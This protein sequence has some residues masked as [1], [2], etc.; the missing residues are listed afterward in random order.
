MGSS[1]TPD[2]RTDIV[3][4]MMAMSVTLRTLVES[5]N[6]SAEVAKEYGATSL[7][8]ATF[9]LS[10]SVSEYSLALTKFVTEEIEDATEEGR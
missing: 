2:E 5:L 6:A 10:E 7:A 8:F 9:H 1:M 3:L 4:R